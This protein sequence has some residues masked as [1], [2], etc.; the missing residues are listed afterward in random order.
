MLIGTCV[1]SDYD[2]N[3]NDDTTY[4]TDLTYY[5]KKEGDNVSTWQFAINGNAL[6]AYEVAKDFTVST[7]A[8]ALTSTYDT[9]GGHLI[10]TQTNLHEHFASFLKLN[11]SLTADERMRS[12][13]SSEL[14]NTQ[15]E[16]KTTASGAVNALVMVFVCMTSLLRF[17][18]GKQ[19]EVLL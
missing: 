19:M 3:V 9:L 16:Y 10:T 7:N 2:T 18:S 11:A 12:G 5:F 6:P 4:S 15:F 14:T 1:N 17:S 8:M 13:Y